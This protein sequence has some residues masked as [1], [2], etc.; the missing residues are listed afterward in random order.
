MSPSAQYLDNLGEERFRILVEQSIAGIYIIQAGRLVYVNARCAE[1][2]GLGSPADIIGTDPA[3]W[4]IEADRGKVTLAMQQL[5]SG[6]IKRAI[7]DFRVQR[8][9]GVMIEVGVNAGLATHAGQPAIIGMIQDI[10]EK[11]QA[12]QKIQRYI[13]QLQS[14]I[15][16]TVGVAMT[17]GEMRDPYTAGHERKVA[18]LA[19]AIGAELGFDQPHQEGLRIASHL[20]DIGKITVPLEILVKPSRLTTLEYQMIKGHAQ[21]SYEILKSVDFPWPVAQIVLQHHERIDGSGYP[22]GLKADAILLDSKIIAVADVVESMSSHRP[23]RAS[24]GIDI[25]LAE[26]ERGQGTQQDY[27]QAH[28]WINLAISRLVADEKEIRDKAVKIRDLLA[29]KMTPAQIAEAQRLARE[30]KPTPAK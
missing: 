20:H 13:E 25:A 10:S 12:E 6:E 26:I 14:A 18:T 30:W 23:Y 11:R 9:D 16:S 17:I 2:V 28:K 22:H 1:I 4:S 24:L 19:V 8:H 27:V 3:G 21:A 7:L 29:A 5:L 15:M